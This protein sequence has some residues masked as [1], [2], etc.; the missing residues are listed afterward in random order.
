[1]CESILEPPAATQAV[2]HP[3]E[4]MA[5]GVEWQ[6]LGDIDSNFLAQGTR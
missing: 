1:M 4:G 2:A 5:T 6:L 3:A